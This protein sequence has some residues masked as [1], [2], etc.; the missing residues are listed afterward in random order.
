MRTIYK[1]L[2]LLTFGLFISTAANAQ[3]TGLTKGKF[4]VS[5]TNSQFYWNDSS[6]VYMLGSMS[7]NVKGNMKANGALQDLNGPVS[8]M[9]KMVLGKDLQGKLTL[10]LD[11]SSGTPQAVWEISIH[12]RINVVRVNVHTLFT[13]ALEVS[14]GSIDGFNSGDK[15]V[16]KLTADGEQKFIAGLRDGFLKLLDSGMNNSAIKSAIDMNVKAKVKSID[17]Q[18]DVV[19]TASKKLVSIAPISLVY[20]VAMSGTLN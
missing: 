1:N 15:V 5:H 9:T 11:L 20:D 12:D 6:H 3:A 13:T 17:L 10:R 16:L 19:L 8:V 2:L 14:Q 4:V 7:T 18:S